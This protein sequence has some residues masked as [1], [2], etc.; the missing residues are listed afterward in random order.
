MITKFKLL[1]FD[2]SES[3]MESYEKQMTCL[4]ENIS[5]LRKD[6]GEFENLTQLHDMVI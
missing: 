5:K 4:K 6:F 1:T 3:K 2:Y